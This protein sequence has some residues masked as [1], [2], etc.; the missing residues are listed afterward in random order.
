MNTDTPQTF[1]LL[2][3]EVLDTFPPQIGDYVRYLHIIILQ[4]NEQIRQ[5]EIEIQ[6]LKARVTELEARLAKNS[7]NSSKPPSSDGLKKKT[8]SLRGKTDKKP[9]AQLGHQ[10]KGRLQVKEP[11]SVINHAPLKCNDCGHN[12]EQVEGFCAEK[13]QVFEIPQPQIEVI[14]HRVEEK[15]C[16]C[17]GLSN[18]G[19]FP[20]DVK[21]PVQFGSRVQAL[22]T[23]FAHQHFIPVDRVC[24]IFEDVFDV[25]I[26][27]GTCSNYSDRL[28]FHLEAF[29]KSL[30]TH[31][32]AAKILHFDETG[33]RCEKKLH[34]VHVASSQT[35]TLYIIHQKRGCEA[36]DEAGVLP[37]FNGVGVHDHW[38]PYFSYTKVLHGLCNAHHLRELTFIYEVK[39]E[40]WA[41]KMKDLL[42][43][44]K[45]VVEKYYERGSMPP[46]E[47]IQ[48]ESIYGKIVDDG[49]AYHAS[50][51]PL[52]QKKRGKKKQREGK[53]LLD[54]FLEKKECVLRFIHDFSVPFTNNQGEQDIRMVKLKQ[55]ISGCFRTLMGGRIFC[56]IRSYISTARKQGWRIWDALSEAVKGSPRLLAEIN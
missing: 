44:A 47:I 4:Q 22:V 43:R 35:S 1:E 48:I 33:M 56:R 12:L 14:E 29:E 38:F 53:N 34:W 6:V 46:E 7:S 25:S 10:G 50:L 41:K 18:R 27:P 11:D 30:K 37:N 23:Y 16:P 39:G 26:S 49:I 2:S 21:G 32:L 15:R 17:C 45:Q 3:D 55:K 54:R 36:M 31:L 20:Q 8:K 13:R 52:P 19:S 24:E 40:E 51:P 42:I 9:G 5:Q 28:Y